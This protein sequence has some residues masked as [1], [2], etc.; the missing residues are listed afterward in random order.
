MCGKLLIVT[1][2]IISGI[3]G[4]VQGRIVGAAAVH[5]VQE[6]SML[7]QGRAT[8]AEHIRPVELCLF[9]PCLLVTVPRRKPKVLVI[10][11]AV[12]DYRQRKRQDPWR[13]KLTAFPLRSL[14]GFSDPMF[15]ELEGKR[16]R[17]ADFTLEAFG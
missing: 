7:G 17:S 14:I 11:R 2:A 13:Y 6:V 15:L 10:S 8:L 3:H 5:T 9:A 4:P 1:P 12:S 16:D